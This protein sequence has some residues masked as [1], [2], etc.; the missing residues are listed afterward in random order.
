M[1]FNVCFINELLC[2]LCIYICLPKFGINQI[3]FYLLTYLLTCLSTCIGSSDPC[4]F[5][6]MVS[7]VSTGT[8]APE[9]SAV[10]EVRDILI[11]NE[12]G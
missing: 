4:K 2:F 3:H 10:P 5:P 8:P 9:T 12:L 7:G 6:G 11:D 1:L